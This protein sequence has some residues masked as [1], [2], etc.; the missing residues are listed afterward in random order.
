MGLCALASRC[1]PAVGGRSFRG[2]SRRR[3]HARIEPLCRLCRVKFYAF[4]RARSFAV[5]DDALIEAV[6]LLK[7]EEVTRL[8]DWF[9][10]RLAES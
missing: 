2:V 1:A 7:Y 6:L 10:A 5:Y 3:Q 9:A 8:G 4:D